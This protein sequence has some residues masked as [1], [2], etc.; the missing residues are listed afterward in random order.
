M[1]QT[2]DILDAQSKTKDA[3]VT[4][5]AKLLDTMLENKIIEGLA[6]LHRQDNLTAKSAGVIATKVFK[7][8]N[9]VNTASPFFSQALDDILGGSY[10]EAG[11]VVLTGLLDAFLGSASTGASQKIATRQMWVETSMVD[12]RCFM[13]RYKSGYT[14]INEY[15]EDG[16]VVIV[17]KHV[18]DLSCPK[19]T[20]L[21]RFGVNGQIKMA[22]EELE[23]SVQNCDEALP[24]LK[25]DA[26]ETTIKY[27]LA[28]FP[29]FEIPQEIRDKG[30]TEENKDADSS[31][32]KNTFDLPTLQK[33]VV[34]LLRKYIQET[35]N[36]K[37]NLLRE[38][39]KKEEAFKG[40]MEKLQKLYKNIMEMKKFVEEQ[41]KNLEKQALA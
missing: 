40:E 22:Q 34:P 19:A 37:D 35:R 18:L 36:Q 20:E 13:F 27:W 3:E 41:R 14:G 10:A 7:R 16:L 23:R 29:G 21:I 17:V 5:A 31:K 26:S 38:F 28:H 39:L 4:A 11:K 25:D 6:K 12:I 30:K 32:P 15:V 8:F 9:V 24:Q 33:D 1:G 2:L